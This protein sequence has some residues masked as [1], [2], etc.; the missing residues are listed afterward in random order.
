[1]KRS[2]ATKSK[3]SQKNFHSNDLA[4]ALEDI[5]LLIQAGSS[6]EQAFHFLAKHESPLKK[7]FQHLDENCQLGLRGVQAWRIFANKYPDKLIARMYYQLE[8]VEFYGGNLTI[9][10]QAMATQLSRLNCKMP[11]KKF[12][13]PSIDARVVLPATPESSQSGREVIPD[14]R[15]D[16][17][18][19]NFKNNEAWEFFRKTLQSGLNAILAIPADVSMAKLIKEVEAICDI[20]HLESDGLMPFLLQSSA[21]TKR[22]KLGIIHCLDTLAAFSNR[23]QILSIHEFKSTSYEHVNHLFCSVSNLISLKSLPHEG[24]CISH[25]SEL[26]FYEKQISSQ[27]LYQLKQSGR[28]AQ[29]RI[30]GAVVATGALPTYIDRLND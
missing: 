20:I 19:E 28:D 9:P 24:F 12:L 25:I 8:L 1:M 7:D 21:G 27:V 16:L 26:F 6:M 3:S 14:Q 22:A 13:S 10:L 15:L 18:S 5:I 17:E 23:L 29:G 2:H 4:E 30:K 11:R